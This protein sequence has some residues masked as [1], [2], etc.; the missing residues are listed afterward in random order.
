MKLNTLFAILL[1]L[2]LFAC[3]N[4]PV[5]EYTVLP[6]PQEI[7][8]QSGFYKFGKQPTI[9]YSANLQA[10]AQL[11]QS[12]L[13]ADFKL[14]A[15][16]KEN[17]EKGNI[18]LR[19]DPSVLSDHPEGYTLNVQ[20]GG[21]KI[22]ANSKDG[23]AHG[24]Q[25]LRQIIT[26]QDTKLSVQKGSI[27]DY[28]QFSWRAFMLD[29]G[30]YFKG[31]KVVFALLD[32]MARLKMNRFHWHLTDDQG[33]R[34]EIK[35]YPKLTEIGAFRDSSEINH[36]GSNVFDGKPH[37]GFYTQEDIKEVIQYAADR[38]IQV[39]PEIEMPGHASAA[40]AAY[41]WIG[42]S[43]KEIKVPCRFGVQ[44]DVYNVADPKVVQFLTDVLEEV[45]ALFP[46]PVIHI[47][48]D[49]VRYN[50]WKASPTVQ[51]YMAQ[52]QL[53][54]PPELQVFFTNYISNFLASKNRRM[55]GWNEITGDRLHEYQ[56]G[57]DVQIRQ[58][59]APS[60]IVHFW[61][62]EN[63]LIKRAVDKGL[64]VVNSNHLF[65]YIDYGYDTTPLEKSYSFS[66]VPEGFTPEQASKIIGSG[67]QM[68]GEFI[69][70]EESMN[71]KIF[72]RIA[73]YAEC[74]WTKAEKKDYQRFLNSLNP[75]LQK[76]IAQGLTPGPTK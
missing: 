36:F 61:K 55:M 32:E 46:F 22:T 16:L 47:G 69:P 58:Q 7:T 63:E 3:E 70:T 30:R 48:G 24:I 28:P 49:E 29:E 2:P 25:T 33:W 40:I 65:T 59:L 73:A 27:N 76:W 62:G 31:K 1:F 23:I 13:A 53:K 52:K 51:K 5:K 54:T 75:L 26:Q 12:Y 56:D 60:A 64:E 10:E 50:Q 72:P 15:T 57:E 18:S 8:Y 9:S 44:Y 43:G 37:G 42:T 66:P 14:P 20:S 21:I 71:S 34:I 17:G 39:V 74:G 35:K 6:E 68:W 67:C 4:P 41:P 19:L 38:H 11:L 45:I